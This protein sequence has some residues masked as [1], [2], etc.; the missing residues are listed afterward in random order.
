MAQHP[1]RQS[2]SKGKKVVKELIQKAKDYAVEFRDLNV[3]YFNIL[4]L[5]K[6]S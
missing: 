5:T 2:S 3:A 6:Q 1:R 4:F